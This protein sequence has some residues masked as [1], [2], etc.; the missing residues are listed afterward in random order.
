M[1]GV[2]PQQRGGSG[3]TTIGMVIAIIVAVALLGVLIWLFTMQEGFRQDAKKALDQKT[4]LVRGSDE[5][6]ARQLFPDSGSGGTVVGRMN[7]GVKNLCKLL[8]GDENDAPKAAADKL[9]AAIED[10]KSGEKLPD[11]FSLV[12]TDGAVTIIQGLSQAY[13]DEHAKRLQ[14]EADRDKISSDLEQAIAS[15]SQLRQEFET[16]YADLDT[17]VDELQSA[18]IQFEDL[19]NADTETLETQLSAKQDSLNS[20]RRERAKFSRQ[21][22]AELQKLENMLVE[23][24]QAI[25]TFRNEGMPHSAE[26]LAIARKPIGTILRALPGD[27]LVHIDLG[28]EDT[29]L[30]GMTFSVY[31]AD[32]R[33]PADGVGKSTIEVVSVGRK[34]SEC[35]VTTPPSPDDPILEGDRVGNIVLSRNRARK[36][37]ICVVGSFDTD[38]DGFVDTRGREEI[39]ALAERYGA[40]IVDS[41]DAT[42]DYVVVGK[43][44][45]ASEDETEEVVTEADEA[46]DTDVVDDILDDEG[47][48]GFEIDDESD[49]MVDDDDEVGFDDDDEEDADDEDAD[50]EDEDEFG[51]DD[52]DADEDG[53]DEDGDDED[54]DEID[55]DDEDADADADDEDGDGDDEDVDSRRASWQNEDVNGDVTVAPGIEKAKP[56]D[57]TLRPRAR[58]VKSARLK[59]F[60]AIRRAEMFAIPRLPQERFLHF[61]GLDSSPST[62][63]LLRQ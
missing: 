28:R 58:R 52:E 2:T 9:G 63:R 51:E 13:A 59:Y 4:R 36:T 26:P 3:A 56:V 44:P 50:D 11:G 48:D 38:F 53:N 21:T 10:L 35:R 16:R 20:L 37:R 33:V 17:K 14:L 25:A 62:V 32:E 18:K 22:K 29:V 19:K 43:E 49:E 27:S 46:D 60:E 57:P 1:A 31:S 12:P 41:V 24:R 54:E 7:Q 55:E 30:L 42:T 39:V 5:Q 15:T 47:D 45:P 8:T 6:T 34:T 61:V 40:E 23:Q